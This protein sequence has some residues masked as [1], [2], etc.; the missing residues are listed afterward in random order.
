MLRAGVTFVLGVLIGTAAL[1]AQDRDRDRAPCS[2]DPQAVAV[3]R[4]RLV[5]GDS[6]LFLRRGVYLSPEAHGPRC[7]AHAD[8]TGAFEFRGLRPGTYTLTMGSAGIE[9]IAPIPV[10]ISGGGTSVVTIRIRAADDL[11]ACM[12]SSRCAAV[13]VRPTPIEL[14]GDDDV[15]L[16]ALGFRLALALS[17][18]SWAPGET[19]VVCVPQPM[20]E[21]LGTV[22]QDVVSDRECARPV[23]EA[24]P[25][26]LRSHLKHTATGRDAI[27]LRVTYIQRG[28]AGDASLGVAYHVASLWGAGFECTVRKRAG[29]WIPRRCVLTVVS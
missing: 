14:G 27:E 19:P 10:R 16:K 20:V 18:R 5:T 29:E 1:G 2:N 22:Y 24:D 21:V 11:A 17:L 15:A 25:L 23:S 26:A 4:G 12:S 6:T 28:E 3:L 7:R 8:S 13:L 9:P